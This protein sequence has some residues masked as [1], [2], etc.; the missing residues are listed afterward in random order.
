MDYAE[1]IQAL[2]DLTRLRLLNLL[3]QA[4][5]ICVCEL[6]DALAL[7]QYAVS[8]H[9]HVLE[10]A[11]F[12]EDRKAGRWVYYRIASGLKPYR[13]TLLRAVTELRDESPVFQADEE[14]ASR[15]L[16]LR[17][18]GVCCVGLVSR[19]GGAFAPTGGKS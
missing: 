11:G 7:P 8:R 9:L 16:S 4:K 2:A 1:Q 12:I 13:R 5:E 18:E 19:I 3:T 15:R 6:V 14:R 17:R 10:Q